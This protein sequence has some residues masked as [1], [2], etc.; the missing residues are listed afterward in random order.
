MLTYW[1]WELDSLM[2]VF[3]VN[4]SATNRVCKMLG[5]ISVQCSLLLLLALALWLSYYVAALSLGWPH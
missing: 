2:L 3:H 5:F 4:S 1:G